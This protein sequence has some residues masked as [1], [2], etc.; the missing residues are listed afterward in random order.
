LSFAGNI[1]SV[2]PGR[3]R[4]K[5]CPKRR[6]K[7]EREDFIQKG[8]SEP[9]AVLLPHGNVVGSEESNRWCY[10]WIS[11]K[12]LV[13]AMLS[14]FRMVKEMFCLSNLIAQSC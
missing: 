11:L 7:R 2:D 6:V 14:L 8:C 10:L 3:T 9:G 5:H 12:G 13:E 4:A 1:V